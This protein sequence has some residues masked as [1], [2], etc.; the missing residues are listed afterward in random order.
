MRMQ[1]FAEDERR[2]SRHERQAQN[3][4]RHQ[5]KAHRE[6]HWLEDDAFHPADEEQRGIRH[7]DDAGGKDHRAL[8]FVGR[9]DDRVFELLGAF[10]EVPHDVFHHDHGRVDDHPKVDRPERDQVGRHM[11][12]LHADE[13]HAQR[14]RNHRRHHGRRP[15]VAQEDEQHRQHQRDPHH[16]CVFDRA[17]GDVEQHLA[18]IERLDLNALG[19]DAVVQLRH[20]LAHLGQHLGGVGVALEQHDAFHHVGLIVVL[21]LA[22]TLHVPDFHFGNIAHAHRHAIVGVDHHVADVVHRLQQAHAAHDELLLAIAQQ[23]AA[24]VVVGVADGRDEL[25]QRDAVRLQFRRRW[26]D[27]VLLHL[28]AEG[29]DIGHALHVLEPL[30][31][32]VVLVALERGEVDAIALEAKAHDLAGGVRVG[33]Q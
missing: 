25:R 9:L 3:D 2:G 27:V 16:Q 29:A 8:H 32:V 33:A 31:D 11:E 18:V 30:G 24:G 21:H 28:A 6:G 14:Q 17:H 20:L 13:R 10:F 23:V 4:R 22:Q 15:E 7:D 26:D 5:G 1:R 19:Q 12:V